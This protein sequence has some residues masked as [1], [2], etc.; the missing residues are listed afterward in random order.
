MDIC[1]FLQLGPRPGCDVPEVCGG[2]WIWRSHVFPPS[3]G[4]LKLH[5]GELPLSKGSVL[6]SAFITVPAGNRGGKGVEGRGSKREGGK[7][8]LIQP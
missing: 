3:H 6:H 4:S 5:G 8:P 7:S 2:A 1:V